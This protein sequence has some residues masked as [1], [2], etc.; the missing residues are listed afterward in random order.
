[1]NGPSK[2]EVDRQFSEFMSVL[3]EGEDSVP[4]VLARAKNELDIFKMARLYGHLPRL[5][6]YEAN[7]NHIHIVCPFHD[8]TN[9]SCSLWRDIGGFKCWS[10]GTKGDIITFI[11]LLS[12]TSKVPVGLI[13]RML[14]KEKL[15]KNRKYYK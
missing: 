10:C 9:P 6:K 4:A 12:G 5:N 3:N 8:D 14:N 15:K 2:E 11:Q 7:S 13:R 1:M